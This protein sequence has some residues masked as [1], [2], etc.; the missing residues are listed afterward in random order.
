MSVLRVATR[1]SAARVAAAA[2]ILVLGGAAPRAFAAE[3][4]PIAKL[5]L[6]QRLATAPDSTV[7]R[8]R[9]RLTTT[10]GKLRAAH[11]AR[12]AALVNARAAGIMARSRLHAKPMAMVL[13][14]GTVNNGGGPTPT[15]VTYRQHIGGV[16]FPTPVPAE[17]QR[18]TSLAPYT[19]PGSDCGPDRRVGLSVCVRASR[20]EGVL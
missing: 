19:D 18:R 5:S 8:I 4:V 16:P 10:L 9:P 20:Y 11:R 12:E 13:R 14:V 15:P 7:V 6:N 3:P 1:V 17:E 2:L